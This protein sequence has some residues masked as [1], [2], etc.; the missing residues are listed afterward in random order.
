VRAFVTGGTGF[1]GQR[2]VARLL[3]EGIDVCC[4]ARPS[5]D[6]GELQARLNPSWPGH[7]EVCRGRL[8]CVESFAGAAR[9]CDVVLHLAAEMRGATAVLFLN[10]VVATRGLIE[11]VRGPRLRRFVLIS[12]LAVY[13][14]GHL[15]PGDRVDET[16]P[17]D[18][19]PHR[20][21]AY[22]Y[23]KIEQEQVAWEAH[24]DRGLPLVAVRP[25]VIYGPGRDCL[26]G[27]LGLRLGSLFVRMGG[28]LP[29]PYTFVENCADAVVRAAVT[30]GVEGESFNAV[31]DGFPTGRALL[32]RY[33]AE[34]GGIRTLTVPRW[35]VGPLTGMYEWYHR[36]SNGQL[37]DVL[38]RYKSGALWKPLRYCCDRARD[39]LGWRPEI[40]SAEG[41]RQTFDWL[42][43]RRVDGALV[44]A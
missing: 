42:R 15:R 35:A 36:R 34:V 8:D 39:R 19:E 18:P 32:R 29:L 2:V 17:L 12:S 7:L 6:L 38:T 16:C 40:D 3:A 41:L 44:S 30:P 20:R 26:T 14:T 27:R 5:S 10:N 21:D 9:G 1:L 24:R 23:S 4:L 25:G 22:T 33:R 13:G 28:R 37:P 31:D 43:A 11:A